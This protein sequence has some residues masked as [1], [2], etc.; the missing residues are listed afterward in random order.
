MKL[1]EFL[2][3]ENIYYG[4][5]ASSK[6]RLLE[7]VGQYVAEYL[8]KE[9]DSSTEEN[10]CPISCFSSLFKREK[11]GSTSINNGVALPHSK[12]SVDECPIFKKPIAVFLRLEKGVDYEAQDNRDVDLVYAVLYPEQ[13]CDVYKDSLQIIANRL[14]D[15]ALLKQLRSAEDSQTIWAILQ[16]SDENMLP[17]L[18][19]ESLS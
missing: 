9:S 18:E 7:L 10:I 19:F 5:D 8:N 17:K 16:Q 15:K 2:S 4:V 14:S 11:L 3:P 12:L 1:T 6:K 13:C